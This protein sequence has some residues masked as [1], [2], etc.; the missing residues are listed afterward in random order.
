MVVRLHNLPL[1]PALIFVTGGALLGVMWWQGYLALSPAPQGVVA[2]TQPLQRNWLRRLAK[3]VVISLALATYAPD[4]ARGVA[5]NW[6]A[7]QADGGRLFRERK[8]VAAM[9]GVLQP[10]VRTATQ[11]ESVP[12][13]AAQAAQPA[14]AEYPVC[15][16]APDFPLLNGEKNL[17]IEVRLPPDC[18]SG[19]I[20]PPYL[21]QKTMVNTDK[22]GLEL[23]FADGYHALL[24]PNSYGDWPKERHGAFRVRMYG[25]EGEGLLVVREE[26]PADPIR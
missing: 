16:G 11:T 17:Q 4:L 20:T 19:W 12:S 21:W 18:L 15:A 5:S 25:F 8:V 22:G 9:I 14:A 13:Q 24:P 2:N 23:W 3:L 1:G 6:W 10:L 7:T 26:L